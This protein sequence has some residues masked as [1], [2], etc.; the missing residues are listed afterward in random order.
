LQI[1]RIE[2][3]GCKTRNDDGEESDD[4]EQQMAAPVRWYATRFTTGN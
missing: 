3:L 4:D 2:V 1:T